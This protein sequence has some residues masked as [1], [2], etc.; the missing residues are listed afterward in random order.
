[1]HLTRVY[2]S[3]TAPRVQSFTDPRIHRVHPRV[4][5][6]WWM[7]SLPRFDHLAQYPLYCEVA[8]LLIDGDLAVQVRR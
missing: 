8:G 7:W 5:R 3:D 4:Y 1:M 2:E 6:F